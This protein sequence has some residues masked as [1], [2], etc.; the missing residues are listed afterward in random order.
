MISYKA[1]TRASITLQL[2][3]DIGLYDSE[4]FSSNGLLLQPYDQSTTLTGVI[5]KNN[6]DITSE[7]KDIRWTMWSPDASNYA[8]DEE[9]NENHKGSNVIEVTSDEIDGKCIIQFEAYKKNKM[10]EDELIACSHITLV[11]INDLIAVIEKPDNPYD[12]QLW[13]DTSTD[14]ATIWVYK[15]GKW[16]RVGTVDAIVKNLIRNSAFT[17]FTNKYYDVVGSTVL[18][19][20]P[21]VFQRGSYN[22][23]KLQSDVA[24]DAERGV[25]YTVFDEDIKTN[26]D[27][28]FQMLA[29]ATSATS[30]VDNRINI[31]ICSIDESNAEVTL[32]EY[33]DLEIT[34]DVCKFFTSFKTLPNTKTIKIYITGHNGSVYDFN[35]SHLAL[36]NTANDYPWQ[37]HPDDASLILDQETV[38]NALTN[39]GTVKG[40]YSIRDPK[41][42]Q[43]Q[44]Y[45][46]ANYI[47]SGTIKGDR[48]DAHNLTVARNDGVKTIEITDKG[49]VNLVVNSLK[50]SSTGQTIEDFILDSIDLNDSGQLKYLLKQIQKESSEADA[51]YTELYNTDELKDATYSKETATDL[52]LSMYTNKASSGQ[53]RARRRSIVTPGSDADKER[54]PSFVLGQSKLGYAVLGETGSGNL[55]TILYNVKRSY[56]GDTDRLVAKIE[57][58]IAEIEKGDKAGTQAIAICSNNEI[59]EEST[60]EDLYTVYID[61]Y[62]LLKRVFVICQDAVGIVRLTVVTDKWSK[63]E[64]E[65]NQILSEVGEVKKYYAGPEGKEPTLLEAIG[66]IAS[67]K[68]T[69]EAIVNIVQNG[70]VDVDKDPQKVSEIISQTVINQTAS[71]INMSAEN[72]KQGLKSSFDLSINGIKLGT[73]DADGNTTLIDMNGDT[74]QIAAPQIDL[75]GYVTFS[76]FGDEFNKNF[77]TSFDKSFNDSFGKKFDDSFTINLNKAFKGELPDITTIN[78]G[79]ITTNTILG[80]ALVTNTITTDK[81]AADVLTA[82][83]IKTGNLQGTNS[84]SYF[85]L[86]NGT[87][88]LANADK[89]FLTFD[90]NKLSFGDV[91]ASDLGILVDDVTG[92]LPSWIKDWNGRTVEIDNENIVGVRA[93]LGRKE[94]T[95]LT[96]IGL[97]VDL[98]TNTG[99][100]EFKGNVDSGIVGMRFGKKTFEL[101]LDGTFKFGNDSRYI[102]F[103]DEGLKVSAIYGEEIKAYNLDV[104]KRSKDTEGNYVYDNKNKT[105]NIDDEGNISIKANSF[106]LT[107]TVANQQQLINGL[108]N[109][110]TNSQTNGLWISDGKLN[111]NADNITTGK[112][113]AGRVNITDGSFLVGTEDKP[114]FWIKSNN[115]VIIK[116]S[117][118]LLTDKDGNTVIEV[119]ENK[120]VTMNASYINTG[121]INGKFIEAET[122]DVSH[123]VAGIGATNINNILDKGNIAWSSKFGSETSATVI[124]NC[125]LGNDVAQNITDK[126]TVGGIVNADNVNETAYIEIDL[127]NTYKISSSTIYFDTSAAPDSGVTYYYKIKYSYNGTDW[128]YIVGN[129][130]SSYQS[131]WATG[132]LPNKIAP[133]VNNFNAESG[134]EYINAR[135]IR[136]CFGNLGTNPISMKVISWHLYSSGRSTIIDSSGITTGAI[137][138]EQIAANS[139]NTEHIN[140]LD[141]SFT[142]TDNTGDTVFAITEVNNNTTVELKPD[143][144]ILKDGNGNV[145][146]SLKDGKLDIDATNITTGK[147]KADYIQGGTLDTSVIK[148]GSITGKQI[149]AK[150]LKIERESTNGAITTFQVSSNGTI[151]ANYEDFIL[152]SGDTN[153]YVGDYVD[154]L[155]D[156]IEE[157]IRFSGDTITLGK[158]IM[159]DGI[160]NKFKAKLSSTSLDFMENDV[161]VASISNNRMFITNA[162]VKNVLTIGNTASGNNVGGF[163]DWTLR[164]NGHLSLK[165]RAN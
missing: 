39:N 157:Y 46:N 30:A 22:W 104:Y 137:K 139:I 17:T 130:Y 9:W 84:K 57:E 126:Y 90:G 144:F 148:A 45:F 2:I 124:T 131:G 140:I 40:L 114:V 77:T 58:R 165:W 1:L 64:V 67:E 38:F 52:D 153:M 23:L 108:T 106:S 28:S 47:Q 41:T 36:Y 75:S 159:E 149:N 44:I 20:T 63:L 10:N 85:D 80:N 113:S 102:S 34:T 119:N 76:K 150:D 133:L 81:L 127:G 121:S 111:I 79:L 35:I 65:T 18:S 21:S 134:V 161:A 54:L 95:E 83:N 5:Y 4:I 123:L 101:K 164:Q 55:K 68:I 27:Y 135:Y 105:L 125:K 31:R 93:F 73:K 43:L 29:Y 70:V 163:F 142:F 94:G 112:M 60:L 92:V 78:G 147:L 12:G 132:I 141:D 15:N 154:A 152:V 42:G 98:G 160:A 136:L 19:Y 48:I 6:K 155:R 143:T 62:S 88:R 145:G 82:N 115:E 162:Q 25:S 107:P 74:I 8:T 13:V 53:Q 51:I 61:K 103:D 87:F 156:D 71:D 151:Y 66:S 26:S 122:I 100:E 3:D 116:P 128:Y 118:F 14:P 120:K 110:S 96:G 37:P 158:E 138:A 117:Q 89:T 146:I 91:T 32:Y 11:D 97:G 50:L 49:E 72:L 24:I 99:E 16:N 33:K 56:N 59:I 7:I 86:D 69:P 109:S 129:K